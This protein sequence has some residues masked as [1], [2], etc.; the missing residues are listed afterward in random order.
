ML[1]GCLRATDFLNADFGDRLV[2]RPLAP[3]QILFD[4]SEV[5]LLATQ[6]H[7]DDAADIRMIGV[8]RQRP[9]HHVEI[10]AVL[11]AAAFVVRDGDNAVHIGVAFAFV[12]HELGHHRNLLRF[13]AGTHTGRD[14]QDE[15]ARAGA[16]VCAAEALKGRALGFSKVIGRRRL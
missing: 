13:V 7:Q 11:A 3:E 16:T 14:N 8:I 1:D 5:G 4:I 9:Q 10:R 12:E 15:V 6:I 2:E